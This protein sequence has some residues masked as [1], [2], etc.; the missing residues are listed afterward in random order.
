MITTCDKDVS[1]AFADKCE[2][3]V[4]LAVKIE[5]GKRGLWGQGGRSAII[6]AQ[7]I[8]ECAHEP[9]KFIRG[10]M[11][12]ARILD[13]AMVEI[14]PLH[15][16]AAN[17]IVAPV[18][19]VDVDAANAY[20]RTQPWLHGHSHH[21]SL[22]YQRLIE[23]GVEG[24]L[25]LVD[26]Y[27]AVNSPLTADQQGYYIGTRI[28]LEGLTNYGNRYR[29]EA[30]RLLAD[31]IDPKRK[32]ELQRM[33]NALEQVPA[34]PARTFFEAIQ[35][36]LLLHFGSRTHEMD[37]AVGRFDY[38]MG[39]FYEADVAA[40]RITR[41][42]AAE[43]I[44]L[45]I[46]QL[47]EQTPFSDCIVVGG[48]QADG[49]T[50]F[51]NDL[52]YMIL[53]AVIHLKL[54]NPEVGFRYTPGHPREF[55]RRGM[56]CVRAGTG[57]PGFFNDPIAIAALQRAGMT[58]EEA[59]DY[60]N[61]NCV[62]LTSCGRSSIISGYGYFNMVKPI[63]IML[64]GGTEVITDT[65]TG[66]GR[67]LLPPDGL[68]GDYPAF[69]DFLSAYEAYMDYSIDTMV[70]DT[71]AWFAR[72]PENTPV[73]LSS[74][75]ITGSIE[76]GRHATLGG[77]QCSQTFPTFVGFVN[78]VNSLLAIKSVVYDR[79]LAKLAD[80][81]RAC[82]N[83]FVG[84]EALRSTLQNSCPRYGNDDPQADALAVRIY[85]RVCEHTLSHRNIYGQ[86]YG[87][88]FFGWQTHGVR[89]SLTATSP[90]GRLAGQ[91][92]SGTL[93]G[94]AGSDRSGPT[95]LIASVTSF[96]HTLAAGGLAVNIAITPD[97][98]RTDADVDRIIDLTLAY[99][100]MGGMQLQFNCVS[101]ETLR[102]AQHHPDQYPTLMVR[103]AGYSD[104]FVN[105]S[106][107]LQDD[108]IL[109]TNHVVS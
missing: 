70:Q 49:V 62:E 2:R 90:D 87:A 14:D 48:C 76:S 42:E 92:V 94:D 47:L 17:G 73:L 61:C 99:F 10:G 26:E 57:H 15:I 30:K 97:S 46:A 39:P 20:M 23:L 86:S 18:N 16:F 95:A 75:F 74:A 5:S 68:I 31:E 33:I 67:T 71:E 109:R 56:E 43:W 53:D 44:Q 9:D 37:S 12:T 28:A 65:N 91:A 1:P 107:T 19:Q 72:M 41:E 6:T 40:G 102:D 79:Q 80:I 27:E 36:M 77:A 98:L 21:I 3:A 58:L 82:R 60:A 103:V 24:V 100:N 35:S 96:D 50:P 32:F 88:Q 7:A 13:M 51:V 78:A 59:A 105:L 55:L 64:N 25:K 66:L 101:P 45:F 108:I 84:D 93:G 81:S 22:N 4:E 34:K 54:A 52:S 89:G 8:R 63:E 104:R 29:E 83:N 11:I 38:Y 85:N 69:D 106:K